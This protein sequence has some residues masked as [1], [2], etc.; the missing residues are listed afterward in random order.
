M[1]DKEFLLVSCGGKYY[2]EKGRETMGKTVT[3]LMVEP[4]KGPRAVRLY[5]GGD[6]LKCAV[7]V[8]APYPCSAE[9]LQ[10]EKNVGILFNGE[11]HILGL[12]KNRLVDGKAIPG[13]F[14]VV[15]LD[16]Q[17]NITSLSYSAVDEWW[18]RLAL[19]TSY[20]DGEATFEDYVELVWD[21]GWIWKEQ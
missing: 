3:A 14:Y 13:V 5:T 18:I 21:D 1:R 10:L 19:E 20:L 15:G 17:G 7:S 2:K 8:G 6:F 9:L 4:G 11:A 16:D 12:Q